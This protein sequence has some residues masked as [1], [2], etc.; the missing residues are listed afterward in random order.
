MLSC[1]RRFAGPFLLTCLAA[2]L[3][4][5]PAPTA[6]PQ[7][8]SRPRLAVLV[9]VDQLRADYLTRWQTLFGDGGFRRLLDQGAWFQN[10]HYP[11]ATTL[12]G[13]GHAS[14]ATGC[15]PDKHG[16][17]ANEWYDRAAGETVYCAASP[18]YA[19]VPPPPKTAGEES[20]SDRKK[21]ERG[22]GSAE[23]LLVPTLADA[24]LDATE[25]KGRVVSLSL[26]D[27]SA[28]LPGGRRPDACYWM[29]TTSGAFVTST[30]YRDRPH[31]WVAAFNAGRPADRWFGREWQRLRPDLDYAQ[32]SGP[33]DVVGAG[34][35]AKQG[36]AFP[37]P[38]GA[39]LTQPARAYYEALYN[40]PFGNEL[41]LD[42]V[43]RAVD[44]EKLGQDDIPD[45]LC[46]SFSSNDPIGHI[47]G[48]DSQ[49]VLDVTLQTDRVLKEL[50]ACLDAR[51]G[52]GRYVLVLTA[53]HGICP[54]PE[55]AGAQGKD[56]GRL[57]LELLTKEAEAFLQA[58]FGE[59][60]GKSR[61]LEATTIPWVYLNQPLLR[62]RGLPPATVEE[63]LARW[64]EKQDGILKAYTR[65]QLLRGLPA[66]DGIGARVRRSFQP[67]RCGDVAVVVKPY[68]VFNELFTTGTTHGTPHE[69]DTHVPLLAYG[70]GVRAGIRPEAVTPQAC[71]AILAQALGI[72][73]PAAAEVPVLASLTE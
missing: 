12:T 66:E 4:C 20:A 42:F 27:R 71:A 31:A 24:L 70:P 29:D 5:L 14:V 64:L 59:P 39:G 30:Y 33:A 28:V 40:S 57:P 46:I 23:R 16:I 68:H 44:A 15:S 50:L 55:V 61:W 9:Y 58:T 45:L 51:V 2:V 19:E 13:P 38:C 48:P 56:A 25:G 60:G 34:S 49:E 7:A 47:W 67:E 73:P 54:L 26:K 6:G 18:R 62:R 43:K 32:Y 72:A 8:T 53:D 21:K 65:T 37:H 11:Y 41:L 63:A 69:Y 17:V 36:R 22:S 52:P 35:G 1:C 3:G 10:C